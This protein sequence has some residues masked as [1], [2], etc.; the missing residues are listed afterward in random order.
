MF[1]LTRSTPFTISISPE[2]PSCSATTPGYILLEI[3]KGTARFV[4]V[5]PD[6]T[7]IKLYSKKRKP[8]FVS[9]R[10]TTYWYSFDW[11][12]L[13]VKYGKGYVMEETTLLEHHFISK[14]ASED[15]K[16]SIREE[17]DFI[18]NP[19][20]KKVVVL[21]DV[22]PL[23]LLKKL[24]SAI[25]VS[26]EITALK[27][28]T[29]DWSSRLYEIGTKQKL[30]IVKQLIGENEG[31]IEV[32]KKVDFFNFPLVSNL[33]P[34]VLNS[35][36]ATL[37]I[38]DRSKAT[39]GK[40]VYLLSASLPSTCLELY[41]NIQNTS[42]NEQPELPAAI[43]YSIKT[44]GCLLYKKLEE[45]RTAAQFG[46]KDQLYLRV[47][48]GLQKG[49]SPGVPYVLEIWP[50][51]CGSPI[52]NH[53][54]TYAV[55]KVL[56]GK[57]KIRVYNKDLTLA[58]ELKHFDVK[59]DDVTWISPNWYQAHKLWNVSDEYCATIQCY[60][61]GNNDNAPWPY[62]DYLTTTTTIEEFLP[63]SDFGF[64]DMKVKVLAEYSKA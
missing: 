15:E 19:R 50:S 31:D 33:S 16:E 20:V 46:E 56:H 53:G 45:K 62:F 26:K 64:E 54:N 47:T 57:L 29:P 11:S 7:T 1:N 18:F 3:G 61:Y 60:Q 6:G 27:A 43:G 21:Y 42:L 23:P 17:W 25:S 38:L 37:E 51:N 59:K 2:Q 44:P 14:T 34:F 10:T 55:I 12:N 36:K 41:S 28:S 48:L 52:H 8:G 49:Q 24:Y 22:S 5:K 32:E 35:S 9:D 4:L 13:V 30:P 58:Q 40:E 39:P 63:D